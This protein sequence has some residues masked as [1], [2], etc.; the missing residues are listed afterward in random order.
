M[1]FAT[2]A[3]LLF[4]LLVGKDINHRRELRI[5]NRCC[6]NKLK[7][8]NPCVVRQPHNPCKKVRVNH[9]QLS[10]SLK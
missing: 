1:R 3:A 10:K 6:T 8:I 9:T 2:R 5:R 4:D 7:Q